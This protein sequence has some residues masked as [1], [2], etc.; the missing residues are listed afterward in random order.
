MLIKFLQVLALYN[1]LQKIIFIWLSWD[2]AILFD[3]QVA[4]LHQDLHIVEIGMVVV[5]V[6]VVAATAK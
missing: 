5:V 6:V 2:F 4:F 1:K 3:I